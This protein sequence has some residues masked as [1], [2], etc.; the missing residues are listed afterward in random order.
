MA[1]VH[2]DDLH[3]PEMIDSELAF[4]IGDLKPMV[5]LAGFMRLCRC[6]SP[7]IFGGDL[8]PRDVTD[9]TYYVDNWCGLHGDEFDHALR[10]EMAAISRAFEIIVQDAKAVNISVKPY[11]PEWLAD[12]MTAVADAMPTMT[13]NIMLHKTPMVL[14]VHLAAASHRKNGGRTRRP[15]SDDAFRKLFAGSTP[16]EDT[17]AKES[18]GPG[19]TTE[20]TEG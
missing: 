16:S 19:S 11:G 17:P 12:F 8:S 2:I 6:H 1:V 20:T 10:C 9:A 5:T 15:I 7:Y 18:T 4:C 3:T 13:P 14:L